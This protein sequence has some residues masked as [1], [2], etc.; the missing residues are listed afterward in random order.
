M[1]SSPGIHFI[2]PSASNF[3]RRSISSIHA[4]SISELAQPLFASLHRAAFVSISDKTSRSSSLSYIA[5]SYSFWTL[6]AM[7][8]S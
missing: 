6:D 7:V 2:L 3:S 1:T 8:K 4:C 5:F